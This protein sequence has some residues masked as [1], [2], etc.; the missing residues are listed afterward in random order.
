[1]R[2]LLKGEIREKLIPPPIRPPLSSPGESSGFILGNKWG[3]VFLVGLNVFSSASI[4]RCFQLRGSGGV[5]E[6]RL[7]SSGGKGV[8]QGVSVFQKHWGVPSKDYNENNLG[9][10]LV[11]RTCNLTLEHLGSGPGPALSSGAN[12][13]AIKRKQRCLLYRVTGW[14]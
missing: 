11:G 10:K 13:T 14:L 12:D 4:D 9:R 8:A 6:S 2:T 5:Q 3:L 7:V 1:M